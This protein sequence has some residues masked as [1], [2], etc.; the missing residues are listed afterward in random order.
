MDNISI[1]SKELHLYFIFR[2]IEENK[3]V[4]IYEVHDLYNVFLPKP[5]KLKVDDNNRT[6]EYIQALIVD[7][8]LKA[9]E[10]Y[11]V[12][13]FNKVIRTAYSEL[14]KELIA[15]HRG[16]LPIGTVGTT[17][18]LIENFPTVYEGVFINS[19]SYLNGVKVSDVISSLML[20]LTK[21]FEIKYGAEY[22]AKHLKVYP[23]NLSVYN[24]DKHLKGVD[25]DKFFLAS[26][27]P[28]GIGNEYSNRVYFVNPKKV[29]VIG[30]GNYPT[31]IFVFEIQ[32]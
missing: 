16:D 26:Y 2:V 13:F 28:Y 27:I 15:N 30:A 9:Y 21:Y 6:A 29:I 17:V 32:D 1:L 12:E 19:V 11:D 7:R 4:T 20:S 8:M 14:D 10:S 25:R 24:I 31:S 22:T 5:R 23:E 18:K 3:D